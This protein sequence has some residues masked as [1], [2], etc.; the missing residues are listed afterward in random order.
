MGVTAAGDRVYVFADDGTNIYGFLLEE[1]ADGTD[2]Q[3]DAADDIGTTFIILAGLLDAT[4][5][6]G[7]DFTA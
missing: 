4:A 5:L 2:K 7:A 3:F 6:T 1:G